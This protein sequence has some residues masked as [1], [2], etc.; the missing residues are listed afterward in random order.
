MNFTTFKNE[1]KSKLINAAT[2][3]EEFYKFYSIGKDNNV[4]EIIIYFKYRTY[5][6]EV[7]FEEISEE[8]K[9][10]SF[11]QIIVNIERN[12][13]FYSI[14]SNKEDAEKYFEEK[15]NEIINDEIN[16]FFAK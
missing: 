8:G 1:L 14:F 3:R 16:S 4:K 11:E 13:S 7:Y 5:D 2:N 6:F 9:M 10:E 12:I 15:R